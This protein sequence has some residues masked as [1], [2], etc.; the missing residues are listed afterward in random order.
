MVS[1]R[2][3]FGRRLS[4][5]GIEIGPGSSPFPL[6][7]RARVR[8][9]DRWTPAEAKLLY[10]ELPEAEFPEPDVVSNLDVD[11]LDMFPSCSVDFVIA[12]HVLE[13]LADP[14]GMLVEIHRVLRPG[15]LAVVLLPNRHQTF[16]R[17]RPATTL[18]HLVDDHA[19]AVTRVDDEHVE[20]FLTLADEGASFAIAPDPENREAFFDWHRERSIHVHCWTEPEFHRV[21]VYSIVSL[22]LSWEF[23]D[24]LRSESDGLE[25]GYLLRRSRVKSFWRRVR[26]TAARA[27]GVAPASSGGDPSHASA[28]PGRA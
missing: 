15:G 16:D 7:S 13:H 5:D 14:L 26:A 1:E 8:Y 17:D 23:V 12:S 20:E 11:R 28:S 6:P 10:P 27:G 21:L 4:G 19:R 25:F 3:R 2:E 9:V 24:R 22:G 18:E